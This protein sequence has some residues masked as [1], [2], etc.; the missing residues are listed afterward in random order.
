MIKEF[1]E[2]WY[3]YKDDLRDFIKEAPIEEFDSYKKLVEILFKK[4]INKDVEDFEDKYNEFYEVQI[5]D[6]SG[7]NVY[8]IADSYYYPN[9][10]II[11]N[12]SYGSCSGC[13]TLLGIIGYS[14]ENEYLEESGIDGIMQILLHLLQHCKKIDFLEE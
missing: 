3:K 12:V 6:Y 11:T 10:C 8:I 7:E 5:G 9:K 1:C 2:K 14:Y 13:D 4:V